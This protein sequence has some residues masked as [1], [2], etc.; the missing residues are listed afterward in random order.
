MKHI[1]FVD[2]SKRSIKPF[3]SV[4]EK[5]KTFTEQRIRPRDFSYERHDWPSVTFTDLT[6]TQGLD[7]VASRKASIRLGDEGFSVYA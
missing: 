1:R 4:K 2:V 6:N 7:D 3:K 5:K